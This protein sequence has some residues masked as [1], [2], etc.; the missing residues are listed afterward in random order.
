MSQLAICGCYSLLSFD[1]TV[2]NMD[3]FVITLKVAE[4][5]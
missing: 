1:A 5:Y 2:K 4:G 3:L